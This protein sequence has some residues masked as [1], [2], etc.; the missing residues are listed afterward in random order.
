MSEL[1][2]VPYGAEHRDALLHI[3]EEAWGPVFAQSETQL[4]QFVLRAFF[5]NGWMP[6]QKSDVSAL[7]ETEADL[8]WVATSHG[9]VAGF[10]GIRIHAEDSMGEIHIIAVSPG[11][12]RA[13]VARALI[14]HSEAVVQ[15]RGMSMMMVETIGD[16][17]HAPARKTYE[18]MGYQQW[19]VARY[20]KPL[21]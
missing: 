13:G 4:P 1:E 8:F 14:D 2:I 12:Q 20:F 7:L 9:R 5:P 10:V 17:G 6:R 18:S 15:E 19:P 3:T 21:D 11:A 16:E